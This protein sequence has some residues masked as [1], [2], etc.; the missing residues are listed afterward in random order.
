MLLNSKLFF[1]FL[2][3]DGLLLEFAKTDKDLKRYKFNLCY[4]VDIV[5]CEVILVW[6]DYIEVD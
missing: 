6:L 5:V 1:L 4:I 3:C 2:F